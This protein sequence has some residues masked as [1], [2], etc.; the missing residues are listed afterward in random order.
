[1]LSVKFD[2]PH[3]EESN[4]SNKIKLV[5]PQLFICE[6]TITVGNYASRQRCSECNYSKELLQQYSIKSAAQFFTQEE[7]SAIEAVLNFLTAV[8]VFVFFFVA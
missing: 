7:S 8:G 1:L 5:E 2:K 6:R 3:N 4:T